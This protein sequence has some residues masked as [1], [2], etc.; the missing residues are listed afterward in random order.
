MRNTR[1]R[2]WRAFT[3][4]ELLVVIAIIGILIA[5][6]LPA[7]QAAREA[8]RRSQCTNNLKQL[9]LS[10][11][12]YHDTYKGFPCGFIVSQPIPNQSEFG[13]GSLVLPFHEQQALAD[14]M[15]VTRSNLTTVLATNLSLAQTVLPAYRC[16]SDV[17][18]DLNN[19]L[20]DA[21]DQSF[22]QPLGTSNYVGS[23]GW[24]DQQAANPLTADAR[25][26]YGANR[27]FKMRDV[28]D[29]TSNTFAI[30]ER[31]GKNCLAGVWPGL[32][33]HDGAGN[34]VIGNT[35]SITA[36]SFAVS[37][38][39]NAPT[40]IDCDRGAS[41]LHPGGANFLFTDGSVHFISETI[42]YSHG[43][44]NPGDTITSG[45][46]QLMGTYQ[47]LGLRNDGRPVGDF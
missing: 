40:Q 3:L 15:G 23:G 6:L 30:S 47:L 26:I 32:D 41:S 36:I 5:L 43:G 2:R 46:L 24:Y 28:T 33:L 38:P 10:L 16:P 4:V 27:S 21:G 35:N 18:E 25:G 42:N 14:A 1:S 29:G 39:I 37:A 31:D 12:N 8:A 34:M 19:R 45:A 44:I 17:A 22:A 9:G 11:H 13:W 7:V 20:N